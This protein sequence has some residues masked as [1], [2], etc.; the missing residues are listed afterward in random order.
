MQIETDMKIS[1]L[2][3]TPH[4]QKYPTAK[5]YDILNTINLLHLSYAKCKINN[6]F[7]IN[8]IFDLTVG[9]NLIYTNYF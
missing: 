1:F 2:Q 7:N 5:S 6:E 8:N 3:I 4:Q 9:Y